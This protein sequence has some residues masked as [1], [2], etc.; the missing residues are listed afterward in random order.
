N[1]SSHERCAHRRM[2]IQDTLNVN[3]SL[4]GTEPSRIGQAEEKNCE[5]MFG[6]VPI[7][8]GYAGPLK[9]TFSSLETS[10]LHLPL[11][12]TEAALVA[13]VNRGCKAVS[14]GDGIKLTSI[15]HGISRTIAFKSEKN[16]DQLI[17]SIKKNED[18]WKAVGEATSNHLKILSYDIDTDDNYLFLTLNADTDEAMGM[19]MITIA[20][21]EIGNRICTDMPSARLITIAGNIDSDKKPSKRTHHKGRGYEVTATCHL[22][23]E[24]CT[25]ILKT[26]P[27]AMLEV[28]EAKL[29]RGS[30]IAGAIGSNLHAANII[31]ALYL[32][33]GQDAAHTVEGSLADT[34]VEQITNHEL[35][36]TTRLPALLCGVRG[37]GTELPAQHQCLALLLKPNTSNLKPAQQL[38]ES[39]G[40]AV[41]AGEISLLAAQAAQKLA[42]SHKKMAR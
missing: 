35:Q 14:E 23:S 11:A 17:N 6:S 32:A 12:T 33:T 34:T 10:T 15:Y 28:A 1:L 27:E 13:S 5:Q 2:Q 19:N 40:A 29:K 41:L 24:T 21:Q 9:A 3:L 4:L 42:S 25:E 38:A 26:T 30:K 8:V 7:P 22:T 18:E 16:I 37:G 20:A 31:A 39:I 36:I